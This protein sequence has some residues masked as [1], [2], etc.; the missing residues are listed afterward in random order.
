ML[1]DTNRLNTDKPI[2]LT[3]LLNTGIYWIRPESKHYGVHLTDEVRVQF[4][5]TKFYSLLLATITG[6][7]INYL[8]VLEL[9]V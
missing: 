3:A 8:I 2:D 4:N 9:Q 1:I 6:F 5:S 7:F